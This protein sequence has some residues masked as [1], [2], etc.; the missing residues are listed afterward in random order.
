QIPQTARVNRK[1]VKAPG[2]DFQ[3]EPQ[4]VAIDPTKVQRAGNTDKDVFKICDRYYMCYQGIWFVATGATGPW[5]VATSVPQEIYQIPVSSPSHH[6]TY[7]TIEE[8][9]D[10]DWVVFA[11][12]AGYTGMMMAWG[13]T[14]WGTV[15][16]YP[17]YW[18]YGG[19]Y[20][21]Y[22][23]YFPTYRYSA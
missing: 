20:P 6:V 13:C 18:G 10:D 19:F 15:W 1:E 7:V 12:A 4:F 9:D 22:Y 2:V 17:P 21:Y 16:Y 8:D 11:A 23:P 5:E 14:V 3:G